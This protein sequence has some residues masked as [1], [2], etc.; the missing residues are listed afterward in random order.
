METLPRYQR[1]QWC[2][3]SAQR[4]RQVPEE[5]PRIFSKPLRKADQAILS[6]IASGADVHHFGIARRL[7]CVPGLRPF[8]NSQHR[9]FTLLLIA[10]VVL[11]PGT[12]VRGIWDGGAA[13]EAARWRRAERQASN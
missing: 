2:P 8:R 5:F 10:Y 11:L 1:N 4:K 12:L 13:Q 7:G 3:R 9:R 6:D